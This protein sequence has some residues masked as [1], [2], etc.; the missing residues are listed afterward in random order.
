LVWHQAKRSNVI[1]IG[2]SGGAPA[3]S[4]C[5]AFY[6]TKLCVYSVLLQSNGV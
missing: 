1:M 2:S 4:A 5:V 3:F 6:R